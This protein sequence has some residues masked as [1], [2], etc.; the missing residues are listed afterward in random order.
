MGVPHS[1]CKTLT[2]PDR[3]TPLNIRSLQESVARGPDDL[4]GAKYVL[5]DNGKYYDLRYKKDVALRIGWIV[6]RT[7]RKDDV[8]VFNRQPSLHRMSMMGHKVRPMLGNTFRLS[9][10]V[11]Q[12]YNADFDGDE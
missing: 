3:V 11:T 4:L 8:V 7:L 5:D 10:S 2:F 6:E 1:I 12:P 9:V